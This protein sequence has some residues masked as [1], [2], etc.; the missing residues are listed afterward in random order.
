[1]RETADPEWL[2]KDPFEDLY[3]AELGLPK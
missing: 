3:D 1:V 2:A